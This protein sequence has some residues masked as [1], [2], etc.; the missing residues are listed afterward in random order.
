MLSQPTATDGIHTQTTIHMHNP[1]YQRTTPPAHPTVRKVRDQLHI[2]TR[3]NCSCGEKN[4]IKRA[5]S[6]ERRFRAVVA[7]GTLTCKRL[8][9]PSDDGLARGW[10]YNPQ[11]RQS[12]HETAPCPTRS[13]ANLLATIPAQTKA[14]A[15]STI[16][17]APTWRSTTHPSRYRCHLRT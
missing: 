9:V 13:L 3:H 15:R 6:P 11:P 16:V 2:L 7:T 4:T 8:L 1:P 5:G 10:Y 12:R 14:T 17:A